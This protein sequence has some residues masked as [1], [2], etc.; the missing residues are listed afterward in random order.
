MTAGKLLCGKL[1]VR[2]RQIHFILHIYQNANKMNFTYQSV[3]NS[4]VSHFEYRCL[5]RN[6]FYIT[7]LQMH[8]K[9]LLIFVVIIV[10]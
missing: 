1:V 5:I 2:F 8:F 10:I 3:I 7:D 4:Y 9:T 6:I